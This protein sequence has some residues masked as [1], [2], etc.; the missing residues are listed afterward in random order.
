MTESRA[1]WAVAAVIVGSLIVRLWTISER[2]LWFDEAFSYTLACESTWAEMVARTATDVHPPLSYALLC[3][4]SHLAG[5]SVVGL[6][7]FSVF[8]SVMTLIGC[9]LF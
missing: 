3:L 9:Y 7:L 5:T 2:S 8:W 4:W 1:R 6:R